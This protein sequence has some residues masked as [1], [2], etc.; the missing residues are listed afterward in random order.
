MDV[1]KAG[2]KYA[3]LYEHLRRRR[4]P[5]V[6]LSLQ[7]IERLTGSALPG[8]ARGA[9]AFWSNRQGGLQSSAWLA[10]GYRV[11]KFD[12]RRG[13]VTFERFPLRPQLH[14][15][16]GQVVWD[17]DAVR[18]LRDHLELNQEGLAEVLGVRQQTVSE[19]ESGVYLPSRS[20]SK[21]LDLVAERSGFGYRVDR[22]PK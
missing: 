2:S 21:H 9:A 8:S 14:R 5:V 17:A 22:P 6:E 1:P 4:E 16:G 19:W 15:A 10:A 11:K 7:T 3:A 18:A 13:R 20:R 12:R